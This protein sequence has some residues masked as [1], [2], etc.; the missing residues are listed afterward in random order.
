MPGG[1][2]DTAYGNPPDVVREAVTPYLTKRQGE[3][4]VEDYRKLPEMCGQN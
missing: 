3:Y 2:W 4:T 1:S